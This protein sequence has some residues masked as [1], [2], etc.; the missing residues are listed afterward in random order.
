MKSSEIWKNI[1]GWE[2]RYEV[3]TFGRLRSMNRKYK[4]AKYNSEVRFVGKLLRQVTCNNGYKMAAL[5]KPGEIPISVYI[6]ILVLK[7]F[8]GECPKGYECC[9][10]DGVR[11]NNILS[12]LR[13][14][15]RQNNALDKH[16]TF[17]DIRGEKAPAAK[18]TWEKIEQIRLNPGRLSYR[19][20]AALF[21]VAH[22][23][24]SDVIHSVTWK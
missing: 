18:L 10:N 6:H 20:W 9:H 21:G 8:V 17:P 23:T 11:S 24:I 13:W 3:S 15:T 2:G 22:S 16:G 7:T 1:P 19:A 12:N 5:S 14:D 4:T